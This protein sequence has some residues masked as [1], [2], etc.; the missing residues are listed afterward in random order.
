MPRNRQDIPREDR[1]SAILDVAG[2]LFVERGFDGV[3]MAEIARLA[4]VQSG[5]LYWYYKSKDHMFAAVLRRLNADEMKRLAGLPGDVSPTDR[6][7][8]YLT[9]M[10][11]TQRLHVSAHLRMHGSAEVTVAHAELMAQVRELIDAALPG[12]LAV[13]RGLAVDSALAA[14]EGMHIETGRP[15]PGGTEVV[16]FLLDVLR[17]SP[18]PR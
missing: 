9:D 12:D 17:S 1:V 5:A 2:R 14:F 4:G 11:P 18:P 15:T 13:D 7:V 6:L 16:R 3:T 8:Y 10:R